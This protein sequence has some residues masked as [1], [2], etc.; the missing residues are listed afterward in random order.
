MIDLVLS[1]LEEHGLTVNPQKWEWAVEETDWLGYWMT[2]TGLASPKAA[3]QLQSFIGMINFYWDMRRHW[4][5]NLT[6]LTALTKVSNKKFAHDW[7]AECDKAFAT[8]KAMICQ[9]ILLTYS[10]PDLPYNIETD[11][12]DKQLGTLIY[13]DSKP[14]VFFQ[15]RAYLSS[16]KVPNY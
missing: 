9:E 4:A 7:N 16:N 12:S 13:Q 15:S 8:V 1:C 2:P 6:P 14:I 3:K 11:A 10:N 5:H